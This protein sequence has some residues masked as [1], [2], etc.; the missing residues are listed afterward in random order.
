MWYRYAIFD[1]VG[2]F[3]GVESELVLNSTSYFA[4]LYDRPHTEPLATAE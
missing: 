4:A 3:R 1:F 2:R